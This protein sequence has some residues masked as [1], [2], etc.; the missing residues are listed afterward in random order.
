MNLQ[1]Q[2]ARGIWPW[3]E[4]P[5]ARLPMHYK[6]RYIEKHMREPVAVHYKHDSRKY[7]LNFYKEREPVQNVPIPLIFPKEADEGLWGGEAFVQGF[8][9]KKE[10]R[11]RPRVWRLWK[12]YLVQRVLYS[13]IVDKWM[14]VTVTLRTLDLIDE[15]Q[16]F[17]KY[18]LA[19]HEVDLCS[20][21][22]MKLKQLFLKT[23]HDRSMYPYDPAKQNA[24]LKKYEEYMIPMEEVEWLGLSIEEAER[25][26]ESIEE[27]AYQAG[28]KPLKLQYMDELAD[29]IKN[30]KLEDHGEKSSATP[31][32][33]LDN[34]LE[35]NPF[36]SK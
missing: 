4:G 17:D 1:Q 15:V 34:V 10:K 6:L 23:L 36:K 26:Q 29:Q 2:L 25:K 31:A 11:N 3:T 8:R 22:G 20:R 21:L 18:I 33:L 32:G 27:E 35:K 19:T 9:K 7:W 30:H 14:L 5:R 12:P 28:I 13:E 24:I 16:G